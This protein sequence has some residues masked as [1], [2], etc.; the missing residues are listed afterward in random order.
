M[1][2]CR[3]R[4][5]VPSDADALRAI[6]DATLFP[7][8]M[9]DDL[10]AP[11]FEEEDCQEF[12]LVVEEGEVLGLAYCVPEPMTDGA[13]NLKAI[14][15]RPDRHRQGVGRRL[16][17]ST[18]ERLRHAGQRLLVVDT[19]SSPE[20]EVACRFYRGLGYEEEARIRDFWAPGEDKITFTK[21]L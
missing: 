11:F 8:E 9:L 7:G 16:M 5:A 20:Q 18:E 4:E 10:I 12:W 14:G 13:W 3:V 6:V 1:P 17:A 19:S 21:R 15:T 2:D